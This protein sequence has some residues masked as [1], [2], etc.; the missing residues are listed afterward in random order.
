MVI[1]A[2]MTIAAGQKAIAEIAKVTAKPI[3]NIVLTH[4][5]PDHVGGLPAYPAGTPIIAQENTRSQIKASITDPN[6]G[7]VLGPLYQALANCLP[8]KTI[9]GTE[10]EVLDGVRMVLMHVA[11]AHR[12]G[13]L[14]VYLPAQRI[15]FGG[16]IIITTFDYPVIH[17]GG[18][19]LGWI[20]SMKAM[21]ALDA[22]T[23]VSGHGPM[24]TKDM[25]RARLRS[26]EQRRE[27]V[28]VMVEQNKSLAEVKQ[29][30]PEKVPDPH[31]PSFVETTYE[32]LAE[33]YPAATPSWTKLVRVNNAP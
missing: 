25:L 16:D 5:D 27:A 7:P 13:D 24:E 21:L 2:Q 14:I 18:S 3:D 31:F 17:I 1:D 20:A 6:G 23:Y 30:L 22:D 11:P 4:G 28:K 32:E 29:A 8:T 10:T 26:V 15:V 9:G 19:S 33:G 12:S